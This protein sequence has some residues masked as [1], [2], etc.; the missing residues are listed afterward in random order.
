M[1]DNLIDEKIFI[2]NNLGRVYKIMGDL[3]R[4]I[5]QWDLC[6]NTI[7]EKGQNL[8][9]SD[10]ILIETLLFDIGV[11]HFSNL[12]PNQAIEYIEGAV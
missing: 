9:E 5:I 6:I 10:S 7:K 2:L 12:R 11:I 4:T 1:V 8:E 3:D